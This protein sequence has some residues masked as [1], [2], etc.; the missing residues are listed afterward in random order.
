[1]LAK[2]SKFVVVVVVGTDGCCCSDGG[3]LGD[4]ARMLSML[5]EHLFVVVLFED[6]LF[7]VVDVVADVEDEETFNAGDD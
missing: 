2:L 6:F 1:M 4:E 7:V 3:G 5:Y